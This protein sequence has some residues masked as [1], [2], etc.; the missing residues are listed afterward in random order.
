MKTKLYIA[1][2]VV[3]MMC[4]QANAANISDY[5]DL[6]KFVEGTVRPQSLGK[7]TFVDADKAYLAM[8][9]DGKSVVKYDVLTGKEIETIF[10]VDN[11]RETKLEY[12]E[13]FKLSPE[14]SKMLVWQQSD[15]IYRNSFTAKYYVYEFRSRLL[16]PLSEERDTQQIP[17]FSP[18]GRMVAYVADNNIYLKKLDYGTDIAVTT[19]GKIN[20]VINGVPDWVYQEEFATT[21]SIT[22]A[23]D[24][25]TLCFLKYNEKDVPTYS[26]EMYE[27]DCPAID[28]YALYPG[29]FT[30]KYPV[31]GCK[32]SVVTLHSY[33]IETRKTLTLSLPDKNIEYI[34]RIK[35]A[36]TP[37]QLMVVTMNRDQNRMEIYSVNPRSGVAKSMLV[38]QSQAWIIP[39]AYENIYYGDDFFAIASNRSGHTHYYKYSYAGAS[40]G[41]ITS[42]DYDVTEYYGYDKV[43]KCHYY[44]S[45]SSGAINRVVSKKD[46]KGVVTNISKTEGTSS[47]T[48]SPTMSCRID[49]YSDANTAPTYTFYAQGKKVK[50]IDNTAYAANFSNVPKQEFFT[51]KS[52][53]YTLNASM[54]K[55]VGFDPSKKYPVV[56]NQYSGPGSQEVLNKWQMGWEN[57][58][59][60][61]GYIVVSVDGRGTGGR[62]RD[63]MTAVYKDLGHYES[64]DQVNA[65]IYVSQLPYVDASRIGIYG[66]S[67]GGYETIMASSQANAPYAAAVAVAPVTDWRF[68]DTIYTERYM[69]TPQQNERGYKA[70][71]CAA[72]I[73][74][75]KC[76]LL[77]IHGTAD[78]NVHFYNT[79]HYSSQLEHAGTWCDVLPVPNANHS[80]Y[81]CGKRSI[82]YA[83]MLEYFN[84]NMK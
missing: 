56:M 64:V 76:P 62:G 36:K 3:N 11:A 30:Y 79:L 6:P 40:L 22:W 58:F 39:E 83:R 72:H 49:Y 74:T 46:A 20:E 48:F 25:L 53:G 24:N 84:K 44:Q 27:G 68:Y 16:K 14:G 80:I 57:F 75:R 67:Y 52:D 82:V 12:I 54:V 51:I 23:P 69:L 61:Q 17:S 13:G 81:G 8:S 65:A 41:A 45:T 10:N 7:M 21:S 60:T 26:F 78:D 34:P 1:A 55:P 28:K 70:S 2:I 43:Q 77:I 33:N 71:A 47:C 9:K 5:K 73:S 15:G 63:F 37:E 59:A 29:N 66:W 19:D 31:A 38:E 35:Y 4:L 50:T 32:N 18:D 42:G